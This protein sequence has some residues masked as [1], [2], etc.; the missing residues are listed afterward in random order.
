[1]PGM[2]ILRE[3]SKG[4]RNYDA[5]FDVERPLRDAMETATYLRRNHG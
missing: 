2:L 1:M 3:V 4:H 5:L